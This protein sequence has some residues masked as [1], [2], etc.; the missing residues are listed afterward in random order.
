MAS[1]RSRR[2]LLGGGL[3]AVALALAGTGGGIVGHAAVP[4]PDVDSVVPNYQ[5]AGVSQEQVNIS[6]FGY[7]TFAGSGVSVTEV[8]FGTAKVTATC[9]G[10]PPAGGC[11]TVNGD[12]SITAFPPASP[13]GGGVHV[14]VVA[15][16]GTCGTNCRSL[17]TNENAFVFTPFHT[18]QVLD[19]LGGVHGVSA[20]NV[21]GTP[22]FGFNIARGLALVPN[23]AAPKGYVLDGW[24]GISPFGGAPGVPS[25]NSYWPGWDIARGIVVQ[26]TGNSGYVLDG[27]GGIHSFGGAATI[28][29]GPYWQGFDIARAIVLKTDT[30]GYVLDG[31]GG[32]HPFGHAPPLTGGPYFSFDIARDLALQPGGNGGYVLDGYGGVQPTGNAAPISGA[33]AYW[34]GWD[35]A[36]GLVLQTTAGNVS[37]GYVLDGYGGVHSF[38]QG[39][40]Q[41]PDV[42]T[43]YYSPS[44]SNARGLRGN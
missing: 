24:G 43:S 29:D 2:F 22:N 41:V 10:P 31:R 17:S 33:T 30:S 11:F 19:G 42:Q 37:G 1:G 13:P 25:T 16:A 12:T 5:N 44:Q 35:I 9:S 4:S 21:G 6:G 3:L 23:G 20:N 8:D 15:S 36:R 14:N 32:V 40:T 38:G 34:N 18:L 26:S 7:Q 27:W 39:A 28:T